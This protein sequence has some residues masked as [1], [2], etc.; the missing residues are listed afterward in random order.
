MVS[1]VYHPAYD[2]YGSVLRN[3]RFLSFSE[4]PVL[5]EQLRLFEFLLLF[6]EF[7]PSFRLNS[8]LHAEF[9]RIEYRPRF[10]YEER[11]PAARLFGEMGPTFAAAFQ[12]LQ[13][14]SMI[15]FADTGA[16]TFRINEEAVPKRLRA[17]IA[18][19]NSDDSL[20]LSFLVKLNSSFSFFGPNGLKARSKLLEYRYDVI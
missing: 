5:Q 10:R 15:Q 20:L 12:T 11:P 8:S 7:I 19:R 13:S 1:L 18:D 6:P 14:K 9:K 17:L 3:L 2:P 16:E 4:T